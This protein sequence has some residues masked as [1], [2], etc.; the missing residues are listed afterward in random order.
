VSFTDGFNNFEDFFLAGH[1]DR[2]MDLAQSDANVLSGSG[3]TI[4][5][6]SILG[7]RWFELNKENFDGI[8]EHVAAGQYWNNG[9]DVGPISTENPRNKKDW[10]SNDG[11][12]NV[13]KVSRRDFS[14]VKG[15]FDFLVA[16]PAYAEI[17]R[18]EGRLRDAG[19]VL[20]VYRQIIDGRQSIT[21]GLAILRQN[22]L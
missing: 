4:L 8:I 11:P 6:V 3:Y 20:E 21:D 2:A 17:L 1:E 15:L 14:G 5:D 13:G 12:R 18:K 16:M 22:G 9:V 7:K 19:I 10:P